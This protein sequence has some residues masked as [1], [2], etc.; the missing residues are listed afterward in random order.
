MSALDTAS[1]TQLREAFQQISVELQ[2]LPAKVEKWRAKV[3]ECEIH[4]AQTTRDIS[5]HNA[6]GGKDSKLAF[7]AEKDRQTFIKSKAE[8]KRLIDNAI[9]EES[10]LKVLSR[11]LLTAINQR[12]AE[13]SRALKK[14]LSKKM[15]SSIDQL[16]DEARESMARWLCAKAAIDNIII[17][18]YTNIAPFIAHLNAEQVIPR[19]TEELI[20]EM[21]KEIAK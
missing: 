14:A 12:D 3:Q 13:D 15:E 7:D 18:T 2:E 10:N 9:S 17:N 21:I 1:V 6:T 20:Q 11:Q 19:R 4:I 5:Y 16:A 8:Y